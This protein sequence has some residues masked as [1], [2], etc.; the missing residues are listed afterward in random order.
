MKDNFPWYENAIEP[1]IQELVYRLRNAGINTTCS[2]GHK[3]YV[4][5]EYFPDFQLKTMHDI[6]YNWLI[7]DKGQRFLN[8]NID[9]H[10]AVVNGIISQS[11]VVIQIQPETK[12]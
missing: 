3:M 1:E 12:T 8:Y 4:E 10:F 2:C 9:I 5:A 11:M 7:E 6:I